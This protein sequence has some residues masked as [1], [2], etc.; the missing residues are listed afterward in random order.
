MQ[1]HRNDMTQALV[2]E[3]L[4]YDPI[5]GFM[6]WKT[7]K[8]SSKVMVGSR[9]GSIST[10]NKHRVLKLLGTLYAEHRLAWL[11]YYGT[12][13]KNHIDHTNHNEQDNRID[14]LSDVTQRVNNM[15]GSKRSDNTVGYVG[16]WINKLNSKKKFMAELKL[17]GKRVHYSSHYT[18]DDAVNA[19]KNA[20]RVFGFHP[21]H[22][23]DKP[24]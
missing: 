7:K 10:T 5:T 8:H 2:Q 3:Y 1:I 6:T 17:D 11:H 20:E 16:V 19:R 15:N 23:I 18:L 22:G 4:D 13:P 12:W 9:A 14:N 24:L 21:N